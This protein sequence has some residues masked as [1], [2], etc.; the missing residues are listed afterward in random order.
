MIKFLRLFALVLV[1]GAFS[2]ACYAQF[3]FSGGGDTAPA[4]LPWVQ[5]HLN[6]TTR[7]KLDFRNASIDAVIQTL[8]KASGVAIVKD[9]AL[10]GG[11][12][13]E[14]PK[15][16]SLNDAFAMFNAVLELKN[17]NMTK[18]GNFLLI[19]AGAPAR[20]GF[21]PGAFAQMG[22]FSRNSQ[23]SSVLDVYTLKYVSATNLATTINNLF[24]PPTA[25]NPANAIAAALQGA[26][27]AVPGGGAGGFGRRGRGGA[28]GGTE[29]TSTGDIVK[30][31][32]DDF[33]NSLIVNAPQ[34][35]QDE[36][37]SIINQIDKPSTQPQTAEVF[38]LN[39]A[40]A[41]DLLP[42]VQNILTNTQTVGRGA[43]TPS[44]NNNNRGGFGGFGGFFNR[45]GSQQNN[46]NGSVSA[47]TR[48]NSLVV[49]STQTLLDQIRSVVLS[50]DKPAA[51]QSS[52][53]IYVMKSARADVVA[54]LMNEALGN[55]ETNGPIGG[56]LTTTGAAQPTVTASSSLSSATGSASPGG[57]SSGGTNRGFSSTNTTVT[58]TNSSLE[59][60]GLDENNRIVNIRNL[61]GNV[62][63]VPDV[64]HNSI[65]VQSPPEDWPAVKSILAEMDQ[66][67]QQVMIDVLVVEVSLDKSDQFGIEYSLPGNHGIFSQIFG[68]GSTYQSQTG[69]GPYTPSSTQPVPT[70]G[71]SEGLVYTLSAGK[72]SAFLQAAATDTKVD[73][74]SS[75]RIYTTNNATAQINVSESV[76]YLSGTAIAAGTSQSSYDFLDVGLI[77][78]VTPRVTSSG[79][80]TMDVSQ[81]ANSILAFLD[82]GTEPEV[83]Q[84]EAETTVSVM[85]GRTVCLGGIIQDT[86][87]STINRVPILSDI[88][89]LGNLFKSTSKSD[90]KDELLVFLTPH[91]VSNPEDS[92]LIKEENESELGREAR[93]LLPKAP[94][95]PKA[96]GAATSGPEPSTTV[97]VTPNVLSV[98]PVQV[99][100]NGGVV[101]PG[102]TT[103]LPQTTVPAP[104]AAQDQATPVPAAPS[105]VLAPAPTTAVTK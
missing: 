45:G 31:S 47:D 24:P 36:I 7:V 104:P 83:S 3:D 6:P 57:G 35:D 56:S 72:Y 86:I 17:A 81:T 82:G 9:P 93:S 60:Q 69:T 43:A 33:S 90:A 14:S 91:V 29:N 50:L 1:L 40:L 41:S 42:V 44:T 28:G 102:N 2:P 38:K 59:T 25:A 70:P 99:G 21:N 52:T 15:P 27:G 61:A 5:F 73:V 105:A 18:S 63:L 98:A 34:R 10:T 103:A 11:I 4:A 95:A 23:P 84:R 96:T 92:Q 46:Q 78:T 26:G 48:T 97:T 74:L 12:T 53:F 30:A 58:G 8:S 77:L 22:Q 100:P 71:A 49:T 55:R 13:L 20:S 39:Y 75:P 76:P 87:N 51:Y 64:D 89:L 79:Y 66:I 94:P 67:P 101:G 32:A 88:P 16:Q 68:I 19:K 62:L 54:N 80:V 85:D 65:I 37:S